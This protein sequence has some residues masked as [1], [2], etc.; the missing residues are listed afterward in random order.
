[1]S[2]VKYPQPTQNSASQKML[3]IKKFV[4]G[5]SFGA[6]PNASHRMSTAIEN[7][8][9]PV[10]MDIM[11]L[12][13]YGL[14]KNLLCNHKSNM[15]RVRH[16]VNGKKLSIF[17]IVNFCHSLSSG[18]NLPSLGVFSMLVDKTGFDIYRI[19]K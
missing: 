12:I 6:Y 16:E 7:V 2:A 14:L 10:I 11:L 18:T 8:T 13:I 4:G 9:Y 17:K 1:M 5:T 19:Y 3:N 15:S